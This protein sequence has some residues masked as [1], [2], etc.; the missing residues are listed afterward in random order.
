MV[1]NGYINNGGIMNVFITGATSGIGLEVAKSL[2]NR[3]YSVYAG[4]HTYKQ[5]KYF[6]DYPNIKPIKFDITNANDIERIGKLDID[7]LICHAGIG[8]GGSIS[9]IPIELVRKNFEV[10]LFS[11]INLIQKVLKNMIKKGYGKIIIT[12]SLF[13]ILSYPFLGVYSATKSSLISVAYA[14][15]KEMKMINKSIHISVVLPGAYHTG[16]NQIMLEN[17]YDFMN[18]GTYFYGQ[19]KKI[20][21]KEN[22]FFKLIEKKELNSIIKKYVNIVLEDKPKFI[23]KA[24]FLQYFFIKLLYIFKI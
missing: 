15:R 19:I 22:L 11:N 4:I 17:K 12:S 6:D 24:P 10:N 20:R 7:I 16:F 18:N 8:I 3:G 23:Y 1:V 2:S 14:L 21:K 9:E 5:K 13:G